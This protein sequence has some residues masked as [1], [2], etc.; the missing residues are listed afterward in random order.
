[1]D[2]L[3][4]HMTCASINRK[5]VMLG[6]TYTWLQLCILFTTLEG[7]LVSLFCCCYCCRRQ[8]VP[9]CFDNN[10]LCWQHLFFPNHLLCH[11]GRPSQHRLK[12]SI[13]SMPNSTAPLTLTT[14]CLTLLLLLL[15]TMTMTLT[16][17]T[18]Y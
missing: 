12:M 8:Q 9:H 3:S 5:R 15:L 13:P 2:A 6:Y 18:Y 16:K 10:Y 17:L 4:E 11:H 14:K 1:M 7:L